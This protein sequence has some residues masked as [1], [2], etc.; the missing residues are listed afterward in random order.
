MIN[1]TYLPNCRF[2]RQVTTLIFFA[3]TSTSVMGA[4]PQ[5]PTPT[6]EQAKVYIKTCQ[7]D[8][9]QVY[10]SLLEFGTRKQAQPTETLLKQINA[11]DILIDKQVNLA[12][13]YANVHP[14]TEMRT[15]AEFC[16]KEWMSLVSE[17]ALSRP[18]YEEIQFIKM[19][20]LNA[21]DKRYVQHM[22][23]D[24]R[25]SG[26]DK[27]EATRQTIKQLNNEIIQIGQEF[28]KNIREGSRQLVLNSVK[29][30]EG[31][32][33]DYIDQHQPNAEG[34]ILLT[35]AYPDYNPFM[36]YAKS[37]A[38]R[39]Q[40]YVLFRQQAYPQNKDVLMKLMQKRYELA[41]IL[42][43]NN[44]AEFVTADKM[45]KSPTNAQEFID[46][47][48]AIAAGKSKREYQV[49]LKRMQQIDPSITQVSDWQKIYAENL[50]KKE[51]YQLDS[52]EIRQYFQYEKV[53]KG[54]FDLTE[55]MF[56]VQIRPWKTDVWHDSVEAYEL[57][58]HNKVIGR[59]YLDMHPRENK[60]N[61]AAQ[62][63]IVNGIKGVQL[64]V[65]AL[66][67]NFPGGDGKGLLEHSDVET[68]LHEFGH[69]MHALF[70]G[71]QKW[72]YFSGVKTEWDFVEAPSQMLEEWVWDE[73]TLRS[74]ATNDK[75]E[76][77]P[78]DLIKKMKAGREFGKGMWTQH[79]LF[80]AA[81]SLN[82]YNQDPAKVDLDKLME[83][84]QA[85]YSPFG[86]VEDTY[87]YTSFGHLNGYSAIY[88]TYMWSLVIAA[89]M[90]SEFVKKGLRNTRLAKHYR[91][92]VLAPGGSGDAADLVKKFLGRSYNFEAFAKDLA[93]K[94]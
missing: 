52:Q 85:T 89:D 35:T 83:K 13:L 37:D 53:R 62:F 81:L 60:Y 12:G 82:V 49:L 74:F 41:R 36:Q 32:P 21:E 4:Q 65:H 28:D 15:A 6:D 88:Y 22:L 25:R 64:P 46:K 68:F 71:Q 70:A 31:M 39:K 59:F 45:I 17:I 7:S 38:L 1:S 56:D 14:N 91:K 42:G 44:F 33:Q 57:V 72:M 30:L 48:S 26:V 80:Y 92:T 93:E 3:L 73:E 76:P 20:K 18:L 94:K 66:V 63:S 58:E 90:H 40:Y 29:D 27:D 5:W 16:E 78:L 10:Q 19:N 50:I 77:I 24:F 51:Q 84:I 69:L 55:T 34:K 54:I 67:C 23:R 86:Y 79:Q 11:M 75:G 9:Q 61:H 43:Y 87:F 8:Y 47:V 2:V